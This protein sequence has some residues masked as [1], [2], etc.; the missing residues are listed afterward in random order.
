[1]GD[2]A[3]PHTPSRHKGAKLRFEHR[4][5]NRFPA[6][7]RL[8]TG[9]LPRKRLAYSAPGGASPL[10]PL[11]ISLR[12]KGWASAPAFGNHPQRIG[13]GS[14]KGGRGYPLCSHINAAPADAGMYL[15]VICGFSAQP[16]GDFWILPAVRTGRSFVWVSWPMRGQLSPDTFSFP[17]CTAHFLFGVSKRKWGVHSARQSRAIPCRMAAPCCHQRKSLLISWD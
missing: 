10:S 6:A 4:R 15:E 12:R 3:V 5:T 17:P 9:V 1:M 13:S 2:A 16:V 7:L 14:G 11:E 8:P